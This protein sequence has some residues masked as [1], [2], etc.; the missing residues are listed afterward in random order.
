MAGL[1]AIQPVVA[2]DEPPSEGM[3]RAG[4]SYG[5][6][7]RYLNLYATMRDD[8]REFTDRV[9]FSINESEYDMEPFAY[10]NEIEDAL[11]YNYIMSG[12]EYGIYIVKFFHQNSTDTYEY[13]SNYTVNVTAYE[14][15]PV[16]ST[17]FRYNRIGNTN[18]LKF[19]AYW[20]NDELSENVENVELNING[21]SDAMNWDE[22][23]EKYYLVKNF[24]FDNENT[25]NFSISFLLDDKNYQTA[26]KSVWTYNYTT[27]SNFYAS[28]HPLYNPDSLDFNVLLTYNTWQNVAPVLILEIDGINQS[29]EPKFENQNFFQCEDIETIDWTI[30]QNLGMYSIMDLEVGVNHTI[31]VHAF[32]G[33]NWVS[34]NIMDNETL[35]TPPAIEDFTIDVLD[36][37]MEK[38]DWGTSNFTVD[39]N[40]TCPYVTEA[41]WQDDAYITFYG[42]W[43]NIPIYQSMTPQDWNDH[44]FSDGKIFHLSYIKWEI[45][46][47]YGEL[48]AHFSIFYHNLTTPSAY[49][50]FMSSNHT[51]SISK[52]SIAEFVIN[53]QDWFV[54]ETGYESIYQDS[55]YSNSEG[56]S[57]SLIKVADFGYELGL[58]YLDLEFF[59]WNECTETWDYYCPNSNF[60]LQSYNFNNFSF[61]SYVKNVSMRLWIN[62]DDNSSIEDWIFLPLGN[63]S[64]YME[65]FGKDYFEDN[66]KISSNSVEISASLGDGAY[67]ESVEYDK[68][69]F[70]VDYS[71]NWDFGNYHTFMTYTRLIDSGNG[72][73]PV[74]V[75]VKRDISGMT[76]PIII[77]VLG[78]SIGGVVLAYISGQFPKFNSIFD[79]FKKK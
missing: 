28:L 69:G 60:F 78:I 40:V 25:Y 57:Y 12:L 31:N 62:I 79:K 11:Q 27:T 19:E 5:A 8:T 47:G 34:R 14:F 55:P 44:D 24:G 76:V 51:F 52:T 70:L 42:P 10:D 20:S 16:D 30:Y 74:S 37:S 48:T 26:N 49:G 33:I 53:K 68:D 63:I 58:N 15:N 72:D 65:D 56:S 67:I 3:I 59:D 73:I 29:L 38:G 23:A 64:D 66:I 43:T 41:Y 18:E 6:A 9:F 22:C 50:H 13:E 39:I 4:V 75:A 17:N 7:G 21:T 54:Y 32:D 71:L 35:I 45:E 36:W 2:G 77:L 1:S 46:E 61:P